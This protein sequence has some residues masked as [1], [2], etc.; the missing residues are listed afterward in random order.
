MDFLCF[1]IPK[2][3]QLKFHSFGYIKKMLEQLK[4]KK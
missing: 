3:E 1:V 4:N 2:Y